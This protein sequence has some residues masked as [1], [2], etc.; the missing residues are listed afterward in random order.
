[1]RRLLLLALLLPTVALAR[2]DG[3]YAAGPNKAWFDGLR[4]EKG[5][6]CSVADGKTI[7]DVDWDANAEGYRVRID[8]QWVPVPPDAV[9][10]VPNRVGVPM[11][12]PMYDGTGTLTGIRCFMPGAGG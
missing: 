8:G 2:D 10:T 4:S 6:C 12:W 7:S 9:V 11:A 1:M 5:L 3:R